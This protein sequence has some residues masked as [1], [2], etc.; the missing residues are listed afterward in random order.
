ML[1]AYTLA[2]SQPGV[3]PNRV[4]G[5]GWVNSGTFPR[6]ISFIN[7]RFIPQPPP[8]ERVRIDGEQVHN[9]AATFTGTNSNPIGIGFTS[10][11]N[12]LTR[13]VSI[14]DIGEIV[15]VYQSALSLT[16]RL[17]TEKIIC[18]RKWDTPLD[19]TIDRF[20]SKLRIMII[21]LARV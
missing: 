10:G 5:S 16:A 8:K 3:T 14:G 1:H 9:Y 20:S 18:Q 15:M 12:S 13:T 11:C 19:N 4:R 6:K 17:T 21:K 7:F 2:K